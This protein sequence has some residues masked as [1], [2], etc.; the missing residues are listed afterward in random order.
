VLPPEK[1][2][3]AVDVPAGGSGPTSALINWPSLPFLDGLAAAEAVSAGVASAGVV[4]GVATA[5]VAVAGVLAC[6]VTVWAAVVAFVA[7]YADGVVLA[8]GD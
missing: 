5:G 1:L 2:G 3:V 6:G 7:G 8:A 4:P